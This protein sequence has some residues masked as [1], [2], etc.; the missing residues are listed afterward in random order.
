[1]ANDAFTG[2]VKIGC[3]TRTVIERAAELSR[4]SGVPLP[5]QPIAWEPVSDCQ[6]VE[7]AV[8]RML[9]DVRVSTDREFFACTTDRAA[10]V[11]KAV[12]GSYPRHAG[13]LPAFPVRPA[14][15]LVM[16]VPLSRPYPVRRTAWRRYRARGRPLSAGAWR[17]LCLGACAVVVLLVAEL[18]PDL[19]AL[20]DGPVRHVLA[21]IERHA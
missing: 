3:T 9:A 11:I 21:W 17:V 4:G 18:R 14:S 10:G 20:P 6:A 8:H 5:F 19:S 16:P 1:M 12:A 7:R 2:W 13:A 15:S